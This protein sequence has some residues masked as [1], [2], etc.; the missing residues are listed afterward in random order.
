MSFEIEPMFHA[1]RDVS[2]HEITSIVDIEEARVGRAREEIRVKGPVLE[3]HPAFQLVG[4]CS[5]RL[6]IARKLGPGHPDT[7]EC[8][9]RIDGVRNVDCLEPGGREDVTME[10]A[11][12]RSVD[13]RDFTL[14]RDP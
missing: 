7:S 4:R 5:F 11:V 9:P 13:A 12:S 3:S 10:P 14:W 1:A 8:G 6:V 2:A